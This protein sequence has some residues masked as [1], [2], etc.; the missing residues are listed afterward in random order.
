MTRSLRRI[1]ARL[2][3]VLG[4]VGAGCLGREPTDRT[5]PCR[6]PCYGCRHHCAYC[7]HAQTRSIA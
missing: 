4:L 7:Y 3:H 5:N 1:E 6:C 2:R